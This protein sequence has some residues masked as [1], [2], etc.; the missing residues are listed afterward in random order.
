[1]KRNQWTIYVLVL[2]LLLALMTGCGAE[3]APEGGESGEPPQEEE[4]QAGG[5]LGARLS[6]Q[7]VDLMSG[8]EYLMKYRTTMDFEGQAMQIEATVAVSGDNTAII[9][10]ANGM[11]STMIIKGDKNYVIDHA[12]K[13]VLLLSEAP[14]AGDS[15]FDETTGMVDIDPDITYLGE[16][17]EGNLTYEEYAS[18]DGTIRYYFDGDDFVKMV[19]DS[20]GQIVTMEIL[21]ISDTVP[22]GIFDIPGD[23]Q[24]ITM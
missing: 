21:E 5:E 2:M 24:L 16:G 7:F 20:N 9:S 6:G 12:S 15:S 22:D 10:M 13:M 17:K 1:M 14:D 11:E 8:D 4:G 19:V 3:S 18:M 23:Y